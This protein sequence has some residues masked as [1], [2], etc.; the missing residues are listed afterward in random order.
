MSSSESSQSI[1]YPLGPDGP[2][3]R[4]T[5]G[6]VDLAE[7]N[8]ILEAG[9]QLA[10][11]EGFFPVHY[12]EVWSV[13][14][15]FG[16]VSPEAFLTLPID[17]RLR[18]KEEAERAVARVESLITHSSQLMLGGGL[19]HSMPGTA[20][21]SRAQL[22]SEESFPAEATVIFP[23]T[24]PCTERNLSTVI[25]FFLGGPGWHGAGPEFEIYWL[26]MVAALSQVSGIPCV[27]MSHGR[28]PLIDG[29]EVV[30][31]ADNR[32]EDEFTRLHVA[33]GS[34]EVVVV[35]FGSGASAGLDYAQAHRCSRVVLQQPRLTGRELSNLEGVNVSIVRAAGDTIASGPGV[36]AEQLR[37]VGAV[38]DECSVEGAGHIL[39]TPSAAR[40]IV[41]TVAAR[42]QGR[43]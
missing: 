31:A 33:L 12:P 34:P 9:E 16:P 32:L 28:F 14:S 40:E 6:P 13:I 15:G 17:Q 24:I 22:V 39:A 30:E 8:A 36:V 37:A 35:A 4:P 3:V 21:G 18:M 41:Q 19:N 2:F 25:R 1:P 23:A 20:W 42:V 27:I 11:L 29:P 38:V 7:G 10:Q 43:R 5:G 26:P